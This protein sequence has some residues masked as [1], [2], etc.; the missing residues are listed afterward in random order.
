MFFFHFFS[1][2]DGYGSL[3]GIVYGARFPPALV[4]TVWLQRVG[5]VC[6][7]KRHI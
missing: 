2:L 3:I 5:S 6:P 4:Y 7:S 1:L